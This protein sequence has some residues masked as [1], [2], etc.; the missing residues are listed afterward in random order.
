[1]NEHQALAT[2]ALGNMMGD[3]LERAIYAFRNCT[4][5]QMQEEYGESGKTRAQVLSDYYA[6]VDKIEKA[7]L[8]VNEQTHL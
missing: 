6:R 2:R 1:M 8:W 7:I 5:E 3:D 4:P